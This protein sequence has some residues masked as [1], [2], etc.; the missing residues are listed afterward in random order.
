MTD[1]R[2]T[3]AD[4]GKAGGDDVELRNAVCTVSYFR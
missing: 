3:V 1:K 4:K 2:D